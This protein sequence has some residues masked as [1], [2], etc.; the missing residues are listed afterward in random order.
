MAAHLRYVLGT[1]LPE[2]L[3]GRPPNAELKRRAGQIA[4]LYQKVEEA[5]ADAAMAGPDFA[6]DC[7]VWRG[8]D[9][10]GGG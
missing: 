5:A 2:S 9:Q 6:A 8:A 10:G 4:D 1:H 7:Q 3:L